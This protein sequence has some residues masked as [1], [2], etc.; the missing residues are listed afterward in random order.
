MNRRTFVCGTGLAATASLAGCLDRDSTE[1]NSNGSDDSGSNATAPDFSVPGSIDVLEVP[2]TMTVRDDAEFSLEVRHG[3]EKDHETAITVT[4][5]TEE[6]TVRVP[7]TSGET[8]RVSVTVPGTYDTV[9]TGGISL[10]DNEWTVSSATIEDESHGTVTVQD[11]PVEWYQPDNEKICPVCNMLT[12]MYEPWAAQGTHPDGTRIEFCSIGCAVAYW[13]DPDSYESERG[14]DGKH[15]DTVEHEL[16]TIWAPDFTDV[17]PD[18]ADGS[19]AAHPGW[20]EYIDMREGYFVLDSR[21]FQKFTTPMPGG[22]P[23]CF[24]DYDDALA[25]VE[26]K[27]EI[28]PDDVDM[29]DVSEGD[30]VTLEKL[31]NAAK[32]FRSD[33]QQL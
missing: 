22:S 31:D 14:Y 20:G 3:G 21:T 9:E 25:Y 5:G 18:P 11:A 32:L 15:E 12:E 26:G 19:S 8:E 24:A 2:T 4:L 1:H 30:I 23:P 28:L 10:G 17:D 16:V 27:L 33:Y 7:V 13:N 6:Q 29:D